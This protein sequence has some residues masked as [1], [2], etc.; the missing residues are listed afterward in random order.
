MVPSMTI[1]HFDTPYLRQ[2]ALWVLRLFSTASASQRFI[3]KD[4]YADA[5]IARFL[6][7]PMTLGPDELS[8]VP[9]IMAAMLTQLECCGDAALDTTTGENVDSFT[10]PT[11]CE[12]GNPQK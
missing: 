11:G 1:D 3:Q 7:L 4:D 8:E 10:P 5:D 6:Q 9:K 2:I 12:S